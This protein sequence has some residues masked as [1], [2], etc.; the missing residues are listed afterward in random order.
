MRAADGPGALEEDGDGLMR[1]I[2][3]QGS[4]LVVLPELAFA[5]W[6]AAEMPGDDALWTPSARAHTQWM[7]R[8][9]ELRAPVIGTR[10]VDRPEGRRNKAYITAVGGA[11]TGLHDKSHPP[12]EPGFWEA[13]RT[14]LATASRRGGDRR[15]A[16]RRAGVH[17]AEVR[18]STRRASS[19]PPRH[20]RSRG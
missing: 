4:D 12:D 14:S 5:P 10:P 3:E 7:E 2:G 16:G 19:W 20:A 11:A 17:G 6:F 18:P 15:P 9:P 13:S 1:H 8:L